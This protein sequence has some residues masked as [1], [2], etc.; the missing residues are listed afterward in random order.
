MKAN[1][2]SSRNFGRARVSKKALPRFGAIKGRGK[3]KYFEI[4]RF[5]QSYEIDQTENTTR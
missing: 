4:A 1:L 3:K 5:C 2:T